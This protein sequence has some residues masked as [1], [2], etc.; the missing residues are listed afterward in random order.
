MRYVTL[1]SSTEMPRRSA[2]RQARTI[3]N[4]IPAVAVYFFQEQLGAAFQH[5]GT[6]LNVRIVTDDEGKKK[7]FGFIDFQDQVYI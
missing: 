1:H 4:P 6:I 2:R 7:G 5:C 3:P